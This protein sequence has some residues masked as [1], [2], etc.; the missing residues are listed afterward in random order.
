MTSTLQTAS[1]HLALQLAYEPA[2]V[3]LH[4]ARDALTA[5]DTATDLVQRYQARQLELVTKQRSG[6]A[7]EDAEIAALH[8]LQAEVQGHPTIRRVIDAEQ[9]ASELLRIVAETIDEVSGVA[10]SRLAAQGGC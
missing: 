3:E 5:D 1:D 9:A 7:L 8:G 6:T 2:V 4:A 10:F